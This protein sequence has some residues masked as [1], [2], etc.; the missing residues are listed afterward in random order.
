MN[1]TRPEL[2]DATATACR[3]APPTTT[4]PDPT[5]LDGDDYSFREA[6]VPA[7]LGLGPM[8]LSVP[9]QWSDIDQTPWTDVTGTTLGPRFVASRDAARFVA[10]FDIPGVFFAAT[11]VAPLD[12]A[13][14]LAELDL[15][16]RCTKGDSVTYEDELYLGR[17]QHWT[18]CG[19]TAARTDVIVANDKDEGRFV[20]V[21]IVSMTAARDDEAHDRIWDSFEVESGG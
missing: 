11:S 20:T 16:G 21:V 6:T 19:S 14:R 13:A 3:T 8:T 9:Q 4:P 15:T 7:L 10:N 1:C 18:A 2:C 17:V 5:I 12:V